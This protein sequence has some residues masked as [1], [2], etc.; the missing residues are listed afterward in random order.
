MSFSGLTK[1]NICYILD[2]RFMVIQH[3]SLKTAPQQRKLKFLFMANSLI[4]GGERFAYVQGL[5][6][7][8]R[9]VEFSGL[10]KRRLYPIPLSRFFNKISPKGEICVYS[11]VFRMEAV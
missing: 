4:T 7:K 9:W 1:V 8:K 6:P 2:S 3:A 11:H 5:I 10:L